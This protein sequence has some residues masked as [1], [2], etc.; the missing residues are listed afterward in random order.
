MLQI[1]SNAQKHNWTLDEQAHLAGFSTDTRTIK[2]D[3]VFIALSGPNFDGNEFVELAQQKGALCAIVSRKID[4]D[5]PQLVV[6]NTL[7]SYG[8][9]AADNKRRSHCKTIAITGSAGKTSVKEMCAAILSRLGNTLATQGNFN[10][11]IGV[12]H[13]LMRLNASYDYAVIELG[14]NHAGEIAY[15]VGLTQPDVSILNNVAP[16][17]IEGFGSIEGVA[18]AKGEIFTGLT[19]S[20]IAVVNGDSE[21]KPQWLQFLNQHLE[22]PEQQI[23]EFFAAEPNS[24]LNKAIFAKEVTTNSDGCAEF[25]LV[26]GEEQHLVRLPIPGRH[27]VANAL[28]AAASCISLGAS[29]DDVAMGLLN[30]K[31]TAG[32][33]NLVRLS[34]SMLLIDDSYNANVGSVKAAI[35]LLA[36]YQG[37]TVLILGDMAEMGP[38]GEQYHIEVGE[39][40]KGKGITQLLS[41]GD[42]AKFA[43]NAFGSNSAHCENMEQLCEQL[44]KLLAQLH[45][46][47]TI[48]IKGSRSAKMER[49]VEFLKTNNNNK[50]E[51]PC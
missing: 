42:L 26:F 10:N 8:L 31:Q 48:L 15:T 37:N 23:I 45:G 9:L 13:T 3:E 36:S 18:S 35:D 40:A 43:S 6:S 28:A 29:L 41:Y 7:K 32:R 12:P 11:E 46:N 20:G 50:G 14:A 17:H 5:L 24:R 51:T 49:V 38:D 4:C 25:S 22:Q 44:S 34:K 16:A 27:N 1:L 21:F 30:M 2:A 19:P 47:T 39:L 33:V